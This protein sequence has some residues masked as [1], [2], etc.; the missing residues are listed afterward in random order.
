[1]RYFSFVAM[2]LMFVETRCT[3]GYMSP[4]FVVFIEANAGCAYMPLPS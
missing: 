2:D 3:V 1:M 4:C